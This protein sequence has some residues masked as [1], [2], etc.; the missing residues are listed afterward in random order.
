MNVVAFSFFCA[1]RNA[2]MTASLERLSRLP[3]GSSARIRSGSFIS[4]RA[5]AVRCFCP[6]EISEGYLSA[7]SEMP[8]IFRSF[9]A[10]A[11]IGPQGSLR[12][13]FGTQTFS[14]IVSP[15]KSMKSWNTKPSFSFLTFA[16]CFSSSLERLAFF[17]DMVPLS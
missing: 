16:I 6:P 9:W 11:S 15:S 7:I 3:V 4:A 17:S 13:T 2:P 8:N 14:R 10:F 12:M 1:S 5:T